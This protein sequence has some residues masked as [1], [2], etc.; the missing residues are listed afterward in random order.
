M[1]EEI[2]EN[3][4][5]KLEAAKAKQ[6]EK[7][8]EEQAAATFRSDIAPTSRV[9]TSKRYSRPVVDRLYPSQY[10]AGRA[11]ANRRAKEAA[12]PTETSIKLSEQQLQ[13]FLDRTEASIKDREQKLKDLREEKAQQEEQ[14]LKQ[15]PKSRKIH[16]GTAPESKRMHRSP[17]TVTQR[18][19]TQSQVDH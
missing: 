13:A 10:Q 12:Q 7:E 17:K 5:Q 19:S 6:K 1:K 9:L 14:L 8:Q 2:E 16:S 3:S 4:K 11:N 18:K 15:K